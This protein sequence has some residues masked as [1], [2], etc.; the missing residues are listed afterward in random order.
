MPPLT[1]NI[2][3]EDECIAALKWCIMMGKQEESIFWAEECIY[4]NM[5]G[6]LLEA[7]LWTWCFCSG[8]SALPW[9]EILHERIQKGI[10]EEDM[11]ELTY[12]LL[13]Y[14]VAYPDSSAFVLLSMGLSSK[15]EQSEAPDYLVTAGP[16][17]ERAIYQGKTELAWYL[18]RPLWDTLSW[19]KYPLLHSISDWFPMW[20]NEM[21][22][23]IRAVIMAAACSKRP[24]NPIQY[25][26]P[27][28]N[29]EEIPM[30]K[31]RIYSIPMDC[32]YLF[33]KR[34]NMRACETTD[35]DL[36]H[37]LEENLHGSR[38]WD[39]Y[40]SSLDGTDLQREE[41]YD[42]F[43]PNDIPDEW[44]RKDR[45][46]SHGAGVSSCSV[47]ECFQ[48]WFQ[49]LP[50][51][52]IWKGLPRAL[53]IWR[54]ISVDSG[55]FTNIF[56]RAYTEKMDIWKERMKTWKFPVYKIVVTAKYLN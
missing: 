48:R 36:T 2:Y 9:I 4:S 26:I 53:E 18:A 16:P 17:L 54:G 35:M 14:R 41:F 21:T 55:P 39:E 13:Q 19:P 44:S 52:T 6:E 11:Y 22:W 43:F 28:W 20:D 23:P 40:L 30:R 32:L 25:T 12:I 1:R 10:T 29:L 5:H 56:H 15:G 46:K 3:R 42:T 38:F 47:H 37:H 34:G 27:E 50:S 31:R 45:E 24:V 49:K 33:T 7:L 8:A 51:R